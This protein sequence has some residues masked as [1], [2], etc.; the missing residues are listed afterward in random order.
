[1]ARTAPRDLE[2]LA[3]HGLLELAQP[4][5]G[6]GELASPSRPQRR[7]EA[8]GRAP[9]PLDRP[10]EPV[11]KV[12]GEAVRVLLH[13]IGRA[14]VADAP[15]G[16]GDEDLPQRTG[17]EGVAGDDEVIEADRRLGDELAERADHGILVG[18]DAVHESSSWRSVSVVSARR[19][20]SFPMPSPKCRIS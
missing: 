3:Q 2:R 7:H 4:S 9:G 1:M 12:L 17:H 6:E 11:T 15:V 16:E 20:C 18:V 13:L 19:C 14:H 5:Q 10:A 8:G